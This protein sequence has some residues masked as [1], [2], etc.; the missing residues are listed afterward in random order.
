ML[1]NFIIEQIKSSNRI[2]IPDFGAILSRQDQ[3]G[4]VTYSFSPFLKYNDGV[5]V[6]YLANKDNLAKD[7]ALA[8]IKEYVDKIKAEIEKN[9]EFVFPGIGKM[10]K[11]EKG[12]FK[13]VDES[14]KTTQTDASKKETKSDIKITATSEIEKTELEVMEKKTGKPIPKE[15]KPVAKAPKSKPEPTKEKEV[16]EKVTKIFNVKDEAPKE[17]PKEE[18]KKG[19]EETKKEEPKPSIKKEVNIPKK[20]DSS[21]PDTK[22]LKDPEVRIKSMAK[23]K[24]VE[25]ETNSKPVALIAIISVSV[26]VIAAVAFWY[27]NLI[28]FLPR[29]EKIDKTVTEEI[30]SP[31]QESHSEMAM[32]DSSKTENAAQNMEEQNAEITENKIEETIKEEQP[33]TLT[34]QQVTEG[35]SKFY[36]IAG[37]FQNNKYAL[38]YAEKMK[39]DG[40]NVEIINK[41]DGMHAVAIFSFQTNGEAVQKLKELREQQKQVW[42]LKY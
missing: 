18:V 19:L 40:Y 42:I 16:T 2:I 38:S 23:E 36:I 7:D 9:K 10:T 21:K 11:D 14:Q 3:K 39:T 37:S 35:S 17:T 41:Q 20:D 8:Q 22:N 12:N 25:T 15:V 31:D 1:T 5:I 30:H 28:P 29:G 27:F 33:K 4:N 6:N 26:I 34:I 13:L 24:K 32:A